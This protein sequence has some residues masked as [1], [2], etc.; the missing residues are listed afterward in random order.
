MNI[1]FYS[2]H[3][4]TLCELKQ[5]A[6]KHNCKIIFGFDAS[7][8]EDIDEDI[9]LECGFS[10]DMQEYLDQCFL[11][12]KLSKYSKVWFELY[13]ANNNTHNVLTYM[14]NYCSFC[15]EVD[16][17]DCDEEF[18]NFLENHY[19]VGECC[20]GQYY[21]NFDNKPTIIDGFNN[22]EKIK[23]FRVYRPEMAL[24]YFSDLVCEYLGEEKIMR[25]Y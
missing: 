7:A 9:L 22:K 15:L 12:D 10:E 14:N 3:M 24:K 16:K 11:E 18:I 4:D 1:S 19:D 21:C 13:D 17:Y 25:T 23:D 2:A 20:S 5:M 6:E 8:S